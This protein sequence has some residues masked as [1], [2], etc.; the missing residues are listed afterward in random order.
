MYHIQWPFVLVLFLV[1]VLSTQLKAQTDEPVPASEVIGVLVQFVVGSFGDLEFVGDLRLQNL[2]TNPCFV[3]LRFG[4][5]AGQL[6]SVPLLANG[7]PI[8]DGAAH[9]RHGGL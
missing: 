7:V 3:T 5:G 9:R 2:S 8:E 1:L 6:P 4:E